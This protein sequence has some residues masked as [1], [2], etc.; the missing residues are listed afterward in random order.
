MIRALDICEESIVAVPASTH[1]S[2][3]FVMKRAGILP[4]YQ[5]LLDR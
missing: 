3:V 5:G 2:G 4:V 1:E